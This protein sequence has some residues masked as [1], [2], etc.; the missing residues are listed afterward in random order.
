LV[1]PSTAIVQTVDFT[2]SGTASGTFY[3]AIDLE[4]YCSTAKSEIFAEHN[5]N[6][7]D[8][9]YVPSFQGDGTNA[10]NIRF[11]AYAHFDQVLVFENGTVY[12]KF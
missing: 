7:D 2:A 8:I 5:T 11:D 12:C 3:Y 1:G 6:T 4:N 9:F 10:Y